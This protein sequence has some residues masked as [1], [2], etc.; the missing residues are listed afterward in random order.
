[1]LYQHTDI[2]CFSHL[3]WNFVYQ[4]PQHLLSRV[5]KKQRVFF[6]EEPIFNNQLDYYHVKKDSTHNVWVVVPH[7][8]NSNSKKEIV[9]KQKK[10]LNDLIYKKNIT[11]YT[12]WYYSPMALTFS[13]HLSPELT[14][15]DCMDELS[16]FKFSPPELKNYE[17][18]LLEK[19]DIVFTGGQSL[20][21]AKKY[22]HHRIFPFPSSIDKKH[23]ITARTTKKEP[24]DQKN[25]PY[26]RLGFYGVLDERLDIS[27]I[28][29]IST[30]RPNWQFILIGPIVKID[31]TTLPQ[32]NNIHYLGVKDY[33]ELPFYLASWDIAL[34]L[35]A[36][37]E[38][39]KFI[40]PTKTPEYLAGGKPVISTPIQDVINPYAT[41]GLVNIVTTA[42][43]LIKTSENILTNKYNEDWLRKVDDYLSNISWDKTWENMNSL[44]Q[45]TIQKKEELINVSKIESYV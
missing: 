14:I 31:P 32:K 28:D 23:F 25:I 33:T 10:L 18:K 34:I 15:Y 43:E 30:M 35:F 17:N 45:A 13:K 11:R 24:I 6:I 8:T 41:L 4:R 12:L 42:T 27:L 44:I 21:E 36:L 3:R 26:P 5:S 29:E 20:F 38:S 39:T 19:A 40:S 2:I 22:K 37:N 1:M 16:S 7:L 9:K